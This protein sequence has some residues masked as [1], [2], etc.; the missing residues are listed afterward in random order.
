MALEE[1]VQALQA[2]GAAHQ[3]TR[4]A[5]E[6]QLKEW[7]SA[8][9][10]FYEALLQVVALSE[11]AP[12]DVRVQAMLQ[13]KNGLDRWRKTCPKCAFTQSSPKDRP[14]RTTNPGSHRF[15]SSVNS[16][17]PKEMK[18]SIRP[19]LLALLSEQNSTVHE[20]PR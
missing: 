12:T 18:S 3:P 1:I 11:Q 13:F 17:I 8:V 15:S 14:S 2:A 9:P 7:A 16:P 6:A 10:Q 4:A 20:F 5:A 19:K